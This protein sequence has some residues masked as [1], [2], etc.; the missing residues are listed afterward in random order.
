MQMA[1]VKG[2]TFGFMSQR[3]EWSTAESRSSL[4]EMKERCQADHVILAVV[5]EQA[6]PQSTTIGWQE[7]SVLSDQEVKG[8]IRY[9]Q[10]LGLKVILKPM[11]NIS[12]GTW[13]AYIN[14]FDQDVPPEPKWSEWFAS[15]TDYLCHYAELA[16]ETKCEMLIIGCELVCTDR[17]AEEWR[18]LIR[19]VRQKY[20]G[21]ISYNCDKYQENHVTWWD[22]VDVISSSGYY[23]I[24]C[25]EQELQRIEPVV[26]YYDKPFFFCEAGCPS[27]DGSEYLPNNWEIERAL[28]LDAQAAWYEAMFAACDKYPWV[29]GFG[30]WDWKAQ[31]YPLEEA[32]E[33]DDYALFGKPVESV[34][35]RYFEKTR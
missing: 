26:K 5:V 29:R 19:Q 31:L 18:G 1:F 23:P 20:A 17:R 24:D 10:E 25:W 8:M 12:D 32:G 7:G 34:V 14:F 35:K 11:V 30:L 13:R 2:V 4:K 22:A 6:T 21:L 9:A 33:D 27:R 16:E 3:G 15:Y 28:S